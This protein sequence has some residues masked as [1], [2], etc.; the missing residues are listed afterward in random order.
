MLVLH[1]L[2][3]G[4][5]GGGASDAVFITRWQRKARGAPQ[6]DRGNIVQRPRPAVAPTG[7][8]P[9]GGMV[10]PRRVGQRTTLAD[11]ARSNR[12]PRGLLS[13]GAA[14]GAESAHAQRVVVAI[15][16]WRVRRQLWDSSHKS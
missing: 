1:Y 9:R 13:I 2:P 14:L 8:A 7:S 15:C 4:F 5:A 16:V 11:S 10:R 12:T 3:V 6:H